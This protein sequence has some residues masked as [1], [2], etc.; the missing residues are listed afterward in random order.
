MNRLVGKRKSPFKLDLSG[1]PK[2]PRPLEDLNVSTDAENWDEN[3]HSLASPARKELKREKK[4]KLVDDYTLLVERN[5][6][7][8][9]QQMSF[10]EEI[11]RLKAELQKSKSERDVALAE[12]KQLSERV[13]DLEERVKK[14][15]N[16]DYLQYCSKQVFR[17]NPV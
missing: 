3:H 12:A 6:A 1:S 13:S 17:F 11:E 8:E 5:R 10:T 9:E 4:T 15:E 2:S 14:F 7:M 16:R